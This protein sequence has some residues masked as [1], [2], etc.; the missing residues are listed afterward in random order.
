MHLLALGKLEF[1]RNL[2]EYDLLE[3]GALGYFKEYSQGGK[4]HST[5]D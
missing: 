3:V 5:G 4:T 1:F 2:G